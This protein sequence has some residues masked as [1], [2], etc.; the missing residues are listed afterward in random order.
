MPFQLLPTIQPTYFEYGIPKFCQVENNFGVPKESG[1]A[2]VCIGNR[3]G[4]YTRRMVEPRR[5]L[6]NLR[7]HTPRQS[8]LISWLSRVALRL[9]TPSRRKKISWASLGH[10][11][12]VVSI[13]V[14]C[15]EAQKAEVRAWQPA[16]GLPCF[17]IEEREH[18]FAAAHRK[19]QS[20]TV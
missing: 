10:L 4:V 9:C 19:A 18:Q 5:K 15:S 11:Q 12:G 2:R 8:F 17:K 16:D 6:Q 1:P 14:R 13:H 20:H 3:R 7:I